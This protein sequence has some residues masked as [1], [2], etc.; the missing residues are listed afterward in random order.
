M[1]APPI[2]LY[3]DDTLA[4]VELVRA[5]LEE[6]GIGVDAAYTGKGGITAYDPARHDAVAIDWNLPD[7]DGVEVAETLLV[8]HP[9][10]PLA[11]VS[12]LFKEEQLAAANTLGVNHCFEKDFGMNYIMRLCAFVYKYA[13][14]FR[15]SG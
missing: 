14:G 1:I 12:G 11:L 3:I 10:C 7:M 8:R 6:Q 5:R 13:G 4:D 9:H 15:R 2:L